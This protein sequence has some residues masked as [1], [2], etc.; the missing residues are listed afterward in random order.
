MTIDIL[1]LCIVMSPV[2]ILLYIKYKDMTFKQSAMEKKFI[3]DKLGD[4]ISALLKITDEKKLIENLMTPEAE[5][6]L[7]S[8]DNIIDRAV[9][10]RY[11][12]NNNSATISNIV[13]TSVQGQGLTNCIYNGEASKTVGLT[14]AY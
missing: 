14:Y 8:V 9:K 11:T 6:K 7:N 1:A 3:S 5:N 4:M 2:W 13:P 10:S 12:T